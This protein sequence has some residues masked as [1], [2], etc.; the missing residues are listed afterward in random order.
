MRQNQYG[1]LDILRPQHEFYGATMGSVFSVDQMREVIR[2]EG[3]SPDEARRL[4]NMDETLTHLV[5]IEYRYCR[6]AFHPL[7]QRFLIIG[8]KGLNAYTQKKRWAKC[9]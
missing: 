2:T 5:L 1:E 9:V 8:Y 3:C 6:L 7:L 4:L